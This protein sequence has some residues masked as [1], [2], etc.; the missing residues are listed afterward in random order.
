MSM[1]NG[2]LLGLWLVMFVGSIIAKEDR[3]HIINNG[4]WVMNF[5]YLSIRHRLMFPI[6]LASEIIICIYC[7]ILTYLW[8]S[9]AIQYKE[10]A[11]N[12]YFYAVLTAIMTIVYIISIV[13][14]LV[15]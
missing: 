14:R 12:S 15:A 5:A 6:T 4:M 10:N 7:G 11:K 2:I 13:V 1:L 8:C 9:N 3:I